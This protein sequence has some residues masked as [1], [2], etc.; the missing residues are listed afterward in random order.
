M[1][2]FITR[3]VLWMVFVLFVVTVITFILMHAVPGGPF[4][5]EKALPES[6]IEQLNEKYNLDD[7]LVMQY[8]EY[9]K[10]ILIP[11]VMT[12]QQQ[13]SLDHEYLI[14]IS[15]PFDD[16]ATLRWVNFGPSYKSV[17]RPV[18]DIFRENLPISAQLGVLGVLIAACIGIPLGVIAGLKRNT[19]Y[20]YAGMGIAVLGVS[21]PV[22]IMA[23]VLQYVF[24]VLLGWLP[25]TGWGEPKQMILPTFALGFSQSAVLARLTRASMLQV[26]HEDYIRTARAKG[27]RERRVV[28]VHVL[29]N[30]MIPVITVIGPMLAYLMAGT[31]VVETIFAIPGMG[32]FFV[33]SITGRDY[34]VIMGTILV[35]AIFLV[36]ANVIVD[37]VYA[38]I[39]PRIRFT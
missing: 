11:V 25:V 36:L 33:T 31:F 12:G 5:T 38:W 19:V 15:L 29:K 1:S 27:L 17:S 4:S 8:V 10:D 18:N 24:G 34:P 32:K 21:V 26:M 9:M 14:N 2:E 16:N 37:V 23:P 13:K 39:D 20:D 28:V 35:M 3:R 30:S 22:I 6:T 7:P